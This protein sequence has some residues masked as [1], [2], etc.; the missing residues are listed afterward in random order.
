MTSMY[1]WKEVEAQASYGG[2]PIVTFQ[3]E[4]GIDP[5]GKKWFC[6]CEYYDRKKKFRVY[7]D[8]VSEQGSLFLRNSVLEANDY[9]KAREEIYHEKYVEYEK[10]GDTV[11]K[12]A[13]QHGIK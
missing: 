13:E 12:F 7:F 8:F 11:K 2:I 3:K 9:W 1:G 10:I 5:D 6:R 4:L